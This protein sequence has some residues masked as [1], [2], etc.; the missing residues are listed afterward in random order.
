MGMVDVFAIHHASKISWIKRL[1]SPDQAKWKNIML[2]SMKTN[3]T[4]LNKQGRTP[5][6][7]TPFVCHIIKYC[8]INKF[9]HNKN[10]YHS[11]K[12]RI[13][14]NETQNIPK[15]AFDIDIKTN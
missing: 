5:Y 11:E 8:N 4:L 15:S 10:E 14:E 12:T 6:I 1:Y 3:Y 9:M 7:K 13:C 2:Q